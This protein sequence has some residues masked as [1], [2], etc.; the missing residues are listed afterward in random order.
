MFGMKDERQNEQGMHGDERPRIWDVPTRAFHWTLAILVGWE[1]ASAHLGHGFLRYHM[2]GGYAILTLLLFRLI[3]GFVGSRTARFSHFLSSPRRT[4][5]YIKS[6]RSGGMPIY[7][8]NPLGG[9]AVA[10]FLVALSVQAGTGLFATD[11][12]LTA[13]P[14]NGLVGS[15]TGDFLTHIHKF[16]FDIILAL[17]ATHV[18]A[19]VL[20]R[21]IGGH[22]L[23]RPMITGR[24]STPVRGAAPRLTFARPWVGLVALALSGLGTW[25]ILQI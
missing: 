21:V 8:H 5:E 7:G 15:N 16:N 12:V 1:W 17:V 6:W 3:W 2:W 24:A 11:D 18:T 19:V 4:W 20:H 13:G 9:W 25:L 22:D 10:G 23:V 14:L